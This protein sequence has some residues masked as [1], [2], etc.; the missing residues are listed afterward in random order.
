MNMIKIDSFREIPEKFTGI[1]D[2]GDGRKEWYEYGE[3]HRINGPAVEHA[4]GRKEWW[5]HGKFH[6]TNGPAIEYINGIKLW[7]L[8]GQ[9]LTEE[10][11]NIIINLTRR[12]K[13]NHET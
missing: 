4:G 7:F 12:V 3:L 10:N 2:Y 1:A 11:F 5:L 9:Q 8:N 13:H 6:R